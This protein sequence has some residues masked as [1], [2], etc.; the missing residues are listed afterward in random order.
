MGIKGFKAEEKTRR[1]PR[2]REPAAREPSANPSPE[3]PKPRRKFR[4]V[5]TP[6]KKTRATPGDDRRLDRTTRLREFNRIA[7]RF[8]GLIP[9]GREARS[10]AATAPDPEAAR[11]EDIPPEPVHGW[12]KPLRRPKGEG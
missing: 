8:E 12:D 6:A 4:E 11:A 9:R 7:P 10:A 5:A 2:R 1:E 3:P